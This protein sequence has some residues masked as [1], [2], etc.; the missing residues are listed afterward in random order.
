M[1][2]NKID[3]SSVAGVGLFL[4]VI[5]SCSLLIP[6]AIAQHMMPPTAS[7]GERNIALNFE[8]VPKQIKTDRDFLMKISFVDQ[9]TKQSIYHVTV[10]MDISKD[11]KHFLSEFFHSHAGNITVDF[12]QNAKSSPQQL[13]YSVGGNM[14]DLTNVWIADPGNPITIDS[15]IFSE[16]GTYRIVLEVTT[17]D[18]DKTDLPQ[19]LKYEYDLLVS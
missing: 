16:P 14:D 13:S 12:R 17:M 19:P 10:R 8:T 5:F 4:M 3:L 9:N 18:N 2:S 15:K 1:L 6:S 7:I 11:Q